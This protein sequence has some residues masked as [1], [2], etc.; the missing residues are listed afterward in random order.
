MNSVYYQLKSFSEKPE[1]K[2]GFTAKYNNGV[3][4]SIT[5]T[6]NKR[7][8]VS[9]TN[10]NSLEKIKNCFSKF[11]NQDIFYF[12]GWINKKGF[13]VIDKCLLFDNEFNAKLKGFLYHQK[14]IY[15]LKNNKNIPVPKID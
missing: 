4:T 11:K 9:I 5:Y 6:K 3:I 7:Y 14:Y 1:N 13:M 12:G 15:D 8:V 10:N 2:N